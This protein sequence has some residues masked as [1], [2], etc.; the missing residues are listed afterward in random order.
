M[1][2]VVYVGQNGNYHHN[3]NGHAPSGLIA[4]ELESDENLQVYTLGCKMFAQ[5]E[6]QLENRVI[7]K[8]SNQPFEPRN[9][10]LLT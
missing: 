2:G 5:G 10:D 4:D 9:F 6:K 1:S 8:I 3:S 7:I